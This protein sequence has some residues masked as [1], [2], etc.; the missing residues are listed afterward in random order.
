MSD[1]FC[2]LPWIHLA[3][4]PD[5]CVSLCC[6]ADLVNKTGFSQSFYPGWKEMWRLGRT[7]PI[8]I[9]NSDSFKQVRKEMLAGAHPAAC[10]GCYRVEALG[11]KSKRQQELENWPGYTVELAKKETD[12]DGSHLPTY[13]YLEL[14]LGN[15]CNLKCATCNPI[16]SNQW[17]D[18]YDSLSEN[19]SWMGNSMHSK[20]LSEHAHWPESFEWINNPRVWSDLYRY[21][22]K[23]EKIYINGGEPTLNKGHIDFLNRFVEDGL[24]E[25]I[26]LIYST[27]VTAIP[28][29]LADETWSK[30]KLVEINASI[31]DIE[32][33]NEHIR[34]PSKW[35]RI[36]RVLE[37]LQSRPNIKLTVIQTISAYNFMYL[38]SFSDWIS[39]KGLA[40]WIN[41]VDAPA[42]LSALVIPPVIRKDILDKYREVIPSPIH[43]DL[44]HRYYNDQVLKSDKFVQYN[45]HLDVRRRTNWQETFPELKKIFVDDSTS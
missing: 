18:D 11:G 17:Q 30:F 2:P 3:S 25:N 9:H 44:Y 36:E 22:K 23:V 20:K 40:W 38:E 37:E 45:D 33:R 27:N 4:H 34:F 28:K 39:N 43:S 8:I 41:H 1:S 32:H 16:S 12:K 10:H 24:S 19:L 5:G 21:S 42:H 35:S 29:A 15:E 31:D 14:R 13:R 26:E 7:Q 6:K